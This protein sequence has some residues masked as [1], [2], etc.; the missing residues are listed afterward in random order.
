MNQEKESAQ[1]I[2]RYKQLVAEKGPDAAALMIAAMEEE[3]QAEIETKKKRWAYLVS[4]GLPP[5]GLYYAYRYYF[6]GTP[7]GKRIALICVVLTVVSL[8]ASWLIAQAFLASMGDQLQQIQ[9]L[10]ADE[11]KD[12]LQ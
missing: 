12:L 7:D 3:R 1:R 6:K 2:E 9:M 10:N 8:L 11:Y 5:F 4:V